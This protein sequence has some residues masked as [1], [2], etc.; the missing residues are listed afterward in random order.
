MS[1][2]AIPVPEV[3]QARRSRQAASSDE[4]P[5]CRRG[6]WFVRITS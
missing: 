6:G 1:A 2:P 5:G 4:P 3:D